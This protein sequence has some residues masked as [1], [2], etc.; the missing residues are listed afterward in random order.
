MTD[1]QSFSCGLL[2]RSRMFEDKGDP[3]FALRFLHS[4][5]ALQAVTGL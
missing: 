5:M 4:L 3:V 2:V 1:G